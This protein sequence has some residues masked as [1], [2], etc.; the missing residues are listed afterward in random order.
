MTFF[1]PSKALA[2]NKNHKI[3]GVSQTTHGE[4]V[5]IYS[6]VTLSIKDL[7]VSGAAPKSMSC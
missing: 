2:E 6:M 5:E 7:H 4:T 1:K 3:F